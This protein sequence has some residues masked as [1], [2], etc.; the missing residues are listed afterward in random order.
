MSRA[1]AP[2]VRRSFTANSEETG[3]LPAWW[4]ATVTIVTA[5][6]SHLTH[7]S[8]VLLPPLPAALWPAQLAIALAA[9]SLLVTPGLWLVPCH[10]GICRPGAKRAHRRRHR[11]DQ[12]AGLGPHAALLVHPDGTTAMTGAM[13]ALIALIHQREENQ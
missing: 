3:S 12:L 5:P 10:A 8:R 11:R 9:G 4:S 1:V 6:V 2:I 13:A 7:P